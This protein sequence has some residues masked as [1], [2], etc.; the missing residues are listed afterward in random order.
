[1]T[2]HLTDEALF[3]YDAPPPVSLADKFGFVPFTTIDRRAGSWQERKR[4]WL[5]LGIASELGRE[6]GLTFNLPI[7]GDYQNPDADMTASTSI[8]D[9]VLG[10]LIYRWFSAADDT[11][12]DPFAGGSVRGIVASHLQR[13]YR[14]IELRAEQVHANRAQVGIGL[15]DYTPHWQVGDA[16][17]IDH[18]LERESADMV[19]TCPPYADLEVYSDDPRDLSNMPYPQFLVEWSR[20]LLGMWRILR[21]DR[22]AAIVISDV[23]GV[24]P[25]NAYRGLVADTINA[26]QSVGFT[27]TN[28]AIV[29]DPVGS[30]AVRTERQFRAS[31]KMGRCHQHL[32]V[33]CKGNARTA[34]QRFLE[35]GAP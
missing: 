10:E 13:H 22:F 1:M 27:L 25:D 6:S 21:P 35:A 17:T 26:A 15:A 34:A 32:L 31:R 11:V 19:M 29:I 33:L 4:R 30:L 18:D 5:S 28:D 14:G 8:F 16:T 23:R 20:A 7:S 12:V 24:G 2:D 9:P 3:D